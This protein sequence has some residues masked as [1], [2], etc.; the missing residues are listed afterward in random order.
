M[1]LCVICAN[2]YNERT[3]K[4]I[5]CNHCCKECCKA[6]IEKYILDST[7]EVHCL[8]CKRA[9]DYRFIYETMTKSFIKKMKHL[10]SRQ[11]M[12]KEKILLPDTQKY[13]EYDMYISC[14]EHQIDV[15]LETIS[16]IN[17][18]LVNTERQLPLK[19]CP[20]T[21]CN[22]LYVFHKDKYCYKCKYKICIHCRCVIREE[23]H[24]C[25]NKR[26]LKYENYLLLIKQRIQLYQ[27]TDELKFKVAKWRLEYA[28]D[29]ELHKFDHKIVCACIQ[30]KC[31]GYITNKEH[32]C[33]LCNIEIC[34]FCYNKLTET[35]SCNTQDIRTVEVLKSSTKPCPN[36]GSLI[37]KIDGC[38]QM[39]CTNCNTAFGWV[40]GK[41]EKG[42]VH[43]PHYFEW[44]NSMKEHINEEE[45]N[46]HLNCSG[47]PEQRYFITHVCL[48]S[49]AYDLQTYNMLL[50][51]FRLLL[52]VDEVILYEIVEKNIIKK[53]LDLRIMWV[54]N[55]ID[56]KK[57][58]TMLYHRDKKK[59]IQSIKNEV[60]KMFVV[61]SSDICHKILA[62]TD[63]TSIRQFAHE[64]NNLIKYV[65]TCFEKLQSIF[66]LNMP[67]ILIE[68]D[69]N[70]IIKMKYKYF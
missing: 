28:T 43:N 29:D 47:I 8:F 6:C 40:S 67:H 24:V 54:H 12:E 14:Q 38:N 10:K 7:L 66:N 53:N 16:K 27:N 55:K 34:V 3:R 64:W 70:F 25:D 4:K 31:K 52:H 32:K 20:N 48:V 2:K 68:G 22:A 59:N 60:F 58:S 21:D 49:K 42:A 13:I 56:D 45:N 35:H 63:I 26:K 15:N 39:W 44:F 46:I 41:I 61:I 9:W 33:N 18:I 11:L 36:C 19:T 50:L 37:Q 62:S 65:N 57:W 17:E 30:D 51:F 5:K 69:Y 23:T 1:D